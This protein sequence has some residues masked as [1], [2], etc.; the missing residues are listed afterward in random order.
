M[1]RGTVNDWPDSVQGYVCIWAS[2][3][4]SRLVFL[5]NMTKLNAFFE[6]SVYDFYTN[7]LPTLK[8][9]SDFNS[10]TRD[11]CVHVLV[12]HWREGHPAKKKTHYKTELE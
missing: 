9:Q 4:I 12:V 11:G 5:D 7:K 1:G 2:W 8:H 10:Y 6:T 3:D